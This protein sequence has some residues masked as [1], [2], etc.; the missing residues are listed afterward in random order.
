MSIRKLRELLPRR[1]KRRREQRDGA[2]PRGAAPTELPSSAAARKEVTAKGRRRRRTP[3]EREELAR[4]ARALREGG[5]TTREVGR[6]LGISGGYVS[7]L[8]ASPDG[9]PRRG[10]PRKATP[11]VLARIVALRKGGLS[12]AAI[13][14]QVGYSAPHVG[15]LL[16]LAGG[17]PL[18]GARGKGAAK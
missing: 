8:L 2:D 16:Q 18:H 4:K 10:R 9:A 15:R 5:M 7:R 12:Y 3:A 14:Q 11:E 6:V 1:S 13:G 17:D